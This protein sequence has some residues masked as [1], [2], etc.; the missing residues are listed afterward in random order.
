MFMIRFIVASLSR[1]L[2]A[3][4]ELYPSVASRQPI[5]QR[6][7]RI[8]RQMIQEL[9]NRIDLFSCT[10]GSQQQPHPYRLARLT[11]DR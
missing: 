10:L 7:Q 1:V 5:N 8:L 9:W 6:W 3:I 4:G 11:A 2:L